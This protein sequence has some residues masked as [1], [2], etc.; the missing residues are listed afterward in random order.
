[1]EKFIALYPVRVQDQHPLSTIEE[2]LH[3]SVGQKKHCVALFIDDDKTVTFLV[4][5]NGTIIPI[6]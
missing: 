4:S 3:T 5:Q 6:M 1:M 2:Q